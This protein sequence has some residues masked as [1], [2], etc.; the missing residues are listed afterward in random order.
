[1]K[2]KNNWSDG[3][4]IKKVEQ[5]FLQELK[6]D[7]ADADGLYV[8]IDSVDLTINEDYEVSADLHI[9]YGNQETETP[10][11]HELILYTR[12]GNL[13]YLAGQFAY[14][15]FMLDFYEVDGKE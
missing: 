13:D 6:R 11:Q 14:S 8:A 5:R 12:D 3:K 10:F 7:Y 1:M 4:F 15:M 9:R 2:T